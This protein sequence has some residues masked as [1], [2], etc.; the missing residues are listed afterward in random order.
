MKKIIILLLCSGILGC[1]TIRPVSPEERQR[2]YTANFDTVWT[3]TIE[4]LTEENFPIKS[5][6]KVNGLI[7][8]DYNK[9]VTQDSWMSYARYTVNLL[10]VQIDKSNTKVIINP[11]YEAHLPGAITSTGYGAGLSNGE[12]VSKNDKD[13][14]LIE[15]Y[16]KILDKKVK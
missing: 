10:I 9:S 3:K 5:M 13:R 12:W 4:M 8:T 1:A 2:I 14:M 7:Q 6:D 16:F 11:S 15:K